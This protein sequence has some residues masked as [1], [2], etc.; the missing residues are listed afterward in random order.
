MSFL[1]DWATQ[2]WDLVACSAVWL[3]FGF[4]AAG[5]ISVLVPSRWILNHL[6]GS[7][8]MSVLKAS[9]FGIP[10]TLCSCSVIPVAS[11]LRRRGA[12]KGATAGFLI[13]TPEIGVDSFALSYA[14]L[15]PVLAIAR[16]LSA[17]VTTLMAGGLIERFD[18]DGSAKG[19]L[20]PDTDSSC[21]CANSDGGVEPVEA[22]VDCCNE[23][24][25][26][27]G[28]CCGETKPTVVA[29]P[30]V[31]DG[32]AK[33]RPLAIAPPTRGDATEV[34]TKN[35]T[36]QAQYRKTIA[37]TSGPSIGSA[38]RY[39][40]VDLL[41]DLA[42]WLAIGFLLAGL[43]Q[44]L[45]PDGFLDRYIGDG[46]LA[47]VAMLVAGLPLYICATSSTP[48]AAALIAQGL[49]PGAA[50][51]FLLVGPA[52]NA[53]TMTVV[54]RDLGIRSLVIYLASIAVVSM[55]AGVGLDALVGDAGI[56][57]SVLGKSGHGPSTWSSVAGVTF[58]VLLLNGL[59]IR[60]SKRRKSSEKASG[61][62]LPEGQC[63]NCH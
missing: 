3:L 46:M 16:P 20:T 14:L 41:S 40:F 36:K 47:K 37:S 18:R 42:H 29:S 23:T 17:L 22:S 55:V 61:A 44:V 57:E 27:S 52:T 15:G 53:A 38:I 50:L 58:C 63:P 56:P 30:L 13:S 60:W 26:A 8:M 45:M 59:R 62:S 19:T 12:S 11:S 9:V 43:V 32:D 24:V 49:S 25:E 35:A 28:D 5:F 51:V 39:G 54:F 6:G 34:S 31:G 21:C 10:L 4:A 33:R 7:G 2:T 1:I 48:L